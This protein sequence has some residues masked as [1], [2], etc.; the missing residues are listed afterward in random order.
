MDF[1]RAAEHFE[2]LLRIAPHHVETLNQL[3]WVRQRQ[4]RWIDA[5]AL[6]ERALAVDARDLYALVN[7]TDNM[8]SFRHFDTALALQR[9]IVA[10]RPASIDAQVRLQQLE[11]QRTGSFEAYD[12]WRAT[13]VPDAERASILLWLMDAYRAVARRDFDAVLRLC[14]APPKQQLEPRW[15]LLIMELRAL[16]DLRELGETLQATRDAL[17]AVRVAD[18]EARVRAL[19]GDREHALRLLREQAR[20]PGTVNAYSAPSVWNSELEYVRLWDEPEFKAIV[21]DPANRAPP[22]FFNEDPV[23]AAAKARGV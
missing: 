4:G 9:R 16:A 14:K 21:E 20:R 18:D 17:E 22:P 1:E 5:N 11:A 8:A 23:L 6:H 2:A 7:L 10:L 12:R 13:L 19:L 15:T 3:A